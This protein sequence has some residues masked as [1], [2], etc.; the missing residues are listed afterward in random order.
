MASAEAIDAVA[1]AG[2]SGGVG[3]RAFIRLSADAVGG[4]WATDPARI[5]TPLISSSSSFSRT[6]CFLLWAQNETHC[7][8]L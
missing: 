2:S 7:L 5:T 4:D 1:G 8:Q 6:N 3:G